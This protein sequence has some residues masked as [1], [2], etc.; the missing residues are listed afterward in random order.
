MI[1]V[2]FS[3]FCVAAYMKSLQNYKDPDDKS[4]IAPFRHMVLNSLRYA[5][6][7][8]GKQWGEMVIAV[9]GSSTW[10]SSAFPYYKKN[11]DS[12]KNKGNV[13]WADLY[14]CVNQVQQEISDHLPYSVIRVNEAE[15]D[16]VIAVAVQSQGVQ[17]VLILSGDKDFIQLQTNPLV[18]QWDT[19]HQRW[20]THAD[21]K[22]YLFEHVIKGDLGDGIPNVYSADDHYIIKQGKAKPITKVKLDQWWEQGVDEIASLPGFKRNVRLIDMRYI[23]EEVKSDIRDAFLNRRNKDKSA[24][25]NY[26]I[27]NN[28]RELSRKIGDF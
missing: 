25:L 6:L 9:D 7:Q 18:K 20:I 26:M 8:F 16:D 28:L 24:L 22:R 27:K 5:N 15:G 2:D 14:K 13:N 4:Q 21:P 23:P 10:R 19:I 1:L 3:Q 17:P 11:R 12:Q